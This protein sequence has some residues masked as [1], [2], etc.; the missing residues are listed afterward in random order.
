MGNTPAGRRKWHAPVL[1]IALAAGLGVTSLPAYADGPAPNAVTVDGLWNQSDGIRADSGWYFLQTWWDQAGLALNRDPAQRGLAELGQANAELLN[2][3]S[4]LN[5]ARTNPGPHPVALL[6]PL[7]SRALGA[8]TGNEVRAPLG[9]LF[10]SMNQGMLNVEGRGSSQDIVDALLRH[11][12][13]RQRDAQRDLAQSPEL[14]AVWT[15]N[16]ARD[17]AMLVKIL[18]LAGPEANATGLIAAVTDLDHQR[19]ALQKKH[20][21]RDHGVASHQN[22]EGQGQDHGGGSTAHQG[23]GQGQP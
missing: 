2:A 1:A 15:A 19:Q 6:D 11:A 20:T 17:Q 7:L 13:Q 4:L 12:A 18:A 23:N 5:E 9:S 21:G 10:A 22:G 16:S 3:Y 8:I 14:D